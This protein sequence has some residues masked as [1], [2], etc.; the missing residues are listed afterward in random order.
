[1]RPVPHVR[2]R[3]TPAAVRRYAELS[4]DHN[5]L[6]VDPVYAAGTPFGEPIAHGPIGLQACLD[7][8]ARWLG[9]EAL[10]PGSSVE[11]V[12]RAAVRATDE[13]TFEPGAVE[14]DGDAVR[15]AGD[16]VNADGEAAISVE[17]SLPAAAVEAAGIA[18]PH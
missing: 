1:M 12:F 6:H 16:C 11:A 5:P 4:T 17:A 8:L 3:V 18:L 14:R 15:L 10:P 2:H 9:A 13:V 7:A